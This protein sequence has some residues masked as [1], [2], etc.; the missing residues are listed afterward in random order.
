MQFNVLFTTFSRFFSPLPHGTST[1]SDIQEYLALRG[2]PR[3]FTQNF[4]C[5][6]LL[7]IIKILKIFGYKTFTFYS[8]IFQ[9]LHLILKNRNHLKEIDKNI[10]S[11]L[12]NL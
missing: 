12:I 8:I 2:G 7:G 6:M 10:I 5:F 4:T 3:R 9:L 11:L 1:L